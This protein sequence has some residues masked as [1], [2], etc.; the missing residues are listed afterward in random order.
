[1]SLSVPYHPYKCCLICG[2]SEAKIDRPK[3]L[4]VEKDG[5]GQEWVVEWWPMEGPLAESYENKGQ[6]KL[7][8]LRRCGGCKQA[9]YCSEN[10]Q[11]IDWNVHR[12]ECKLLQDET[13]LALALAATDKRFAEASDAR[14]LRTILSQSQET[15]P[16]IF[17]LSE[18][19]SCLLSSM[20]HWDLQNF[21]NGMAINRM[22]TLLQFVNRVSFKTTGNG[23]VAKLPWLELSSILFGTCMV[24]KVIN[25]QAGEGFKFGQ[26]AWFEAFIFNF[27]EICDRI[28]LYALLED[29][30]YAHFLPD[31]EFP[32]LK[33]KHPTQIGE[34][35]YFAETRLK[36]GTDKKC[37][38]CGKSLPSGPVISAHDP[39]RNPNRSLPRQ[40][41]F[42]PPRPPILTLKP[43]PTNRLTEKAELKLKS[44]LHIVARTK[45]IPKDFVCGDDCEQHSLYGRLFDGHPLHHPNSK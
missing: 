23:Q 17:V 11:K 20:P 45:T 35:Y 14:S 29:N 44:W 13:K 4:P 6:K 28:K 8:P 40:I 36:I 9:L 7:R 24:H 41:N 12:R 18:L 42:L 5:K 30:G 3:K 33:M 37:M 25:E 43:D 26:N 2:S 21:A 39:N 27:G 38:V 10:C 15:S 1:M 19:N 22:N 32:L 16:L 31:S 34:Q